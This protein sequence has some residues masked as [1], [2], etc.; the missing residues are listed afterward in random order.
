MFP[1][2]TRILAHQE[3]AEIR[4]IR[5]RKTT[6]PSSTHENMSTHETMHRVDSLLTHVWMVRT[7]LKHS[8]EAEEDEELAE[9]HRRLYDYM[10]ALG[11]AWKNQDADAYGKLAHKKLRRLRDATKLFEEIQPEISGHMNFLMAARSLRT[12]VDEIVAL[13][14]A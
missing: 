2:M 9:V 7:F 14:E 5:G 4:V 12:A 13:L 10:L 1:R 3:S 11:E 8:E 6:N